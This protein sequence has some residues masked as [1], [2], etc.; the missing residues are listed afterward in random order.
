MDITVYNTASRKKELFKPLDEKK[1]GIYCCGPT[2]YHFAHIGNM[3]AYVFED[4]LVRMFRIFGYDITHVM[5][6]TDVGHLTSDAD[7]GEDKMLKGA[8]REG[9][10]VWDI[11][12]YYTEAFFS[13]CQA[14]NIIKPTIISKA[15]EHIQDMLD[16]IQVLEKKGYTYVANGNVYFDTSKFLDY[17]KFANLNMDNQ[18]K[19]RVGVDENKKNPKDFALWF[20]QSKFDDQAMKW[21]SPWGTGYPGWHIECSAMSRKYLGDEFDIHCG[22]EDHIP[23][24]HTNEIAQSKCAC[25]GKFARYWMHVAFLVDQTG[26]MSKSKGEF[27]TIP[28]LKEKGYDPLSYRYLLLQSS[29][30][31]Q[32]QF[33]FEALDAAQKSLFTIRR[34]ITELGDSSKGDAKYYRELFLEAIADDL[35]TAKSISYIHEVL[36]SDLGDVQKKELL[37]E[38]DSFFGLNLFKEE[39][40]EISEDIQH[41]LD[42]R[43]IARESKD[44]S[45]SD[46]LRDLLLEKGFVVKDSKE[47]QK[48][49]QK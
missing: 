22:G 23:I 19:S 35:N 3:R 6:I 38:F 40:I 8:K 48:I 27:L 37:F 42:E 31:K 49:T 46:A 14:L 5:N 20:T 18:G 11:A 17:G 16:F 34:K 30:R 15:T 28:F 9:K 13:D 39:T 25:D 7:D 2:V 43:Q 29:Y 33:S 44:W 26:K 10:S 32:I 41:I 24:H 21:D 45:K 12:N 4:L 47:G 1:V 36:S